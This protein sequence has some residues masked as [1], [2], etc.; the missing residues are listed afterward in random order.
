MSEPRDPL[1]DAIHAAG[2]VPPPPDRGAAFA[3]AM[4]LVLV[5]SRRR[6]NRSVIALFAAALLAVPAAVFAA[7]ATHTHS[8]IIAPIASEKPDPG[9]SIQHEADDSSVRHVSAT[10]DRRA[11]LSA[12][13]SGNTGGP[14]SAESTTLSGTNGSGSVEGSSGDGISTPT[15]TPTPSP[16]GSPDGGSPGSDASSSSP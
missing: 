16:D 5:P 12:S 10:D 13:V 1:L 11:G 6:L 3:R 4:R 7:R 9:S 8:A 15:P 2:E 14:G